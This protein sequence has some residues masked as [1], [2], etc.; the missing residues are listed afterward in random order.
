VN[1][2]AYLVAAYVFLW[3]LVFGY[4]YS[5][6]RRQHALERDIQALRRAIEREQTEQ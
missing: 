3:A 6:A 5:I 1:N 2:A 4:L